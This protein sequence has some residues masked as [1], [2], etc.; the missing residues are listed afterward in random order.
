MI[1]C[2]L[3]VC[4]EGTTR[5]ATTNAVSIFNII[6][7]VQAAGFPLFVPKLESIFFLGRDDADPQQPQGSLR[8]SGPQLDLTF[9]LTIDFQGHRKTRSFVRIEGLVIPAAGRIRFEV[10]LDGQADPLGVWEVDVSQAPVNPPHVVQ[11]NAPAG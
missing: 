1:R 7:D 6:E 4:A 10:H 5:D 9:P 2:R 3:A 11:E 8:I